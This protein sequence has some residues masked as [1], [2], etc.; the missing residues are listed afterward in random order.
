MSAPKRCSGCQGAVF[1][2]SLARSEIGKATE[3]FAER[4]VQLL[5]VCN[6]ITAVQERGFVLFVTRVRRVCTSI[7]EIGNESRRY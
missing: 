1:V 5:E 3:R 7:S 6:C 2:A 4:R